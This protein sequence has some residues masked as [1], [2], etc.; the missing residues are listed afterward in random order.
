MRVWRGRRARPLYTLV[1]HVGQ[2]AAIA[3]SP[4]GAFLATASTD[5]IGRVWNA[6]NGRPVSVLSGH[7]NFLEDIA[8][9]RDGEQ[10]ATASSDR[11]ART[12]K[13]RTGALC[14]HVRGKQRR[15]QLRRF[16]P[17]GLEIVTAGLD[18]TARTWDAVVQPTSRSSRA[19]ARP[20]RTSPSLV[21]GRAVSAV[22]GRQVVLDRAAER[23]GEG[24]GGCATGR[25]RG[26]GPGG[27]RAVIKGKDVV[28]THAD[29]TTVTLDRAHVG[30]H[31]A[32]RS[33]PT[34]PGS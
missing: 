8:F 11:T 9:S 20:S 15:R 2:I 23:P 34:A 18:G 3:F 28:V 21:E 22:G 1:G 29:G 17:T 16:T 27:R 31:V 4:R 25:G 30:R 6:K 13:T 26:E 12:W 5:G 7:K 14:S 19:W 24:R 32:S 33:R 10:I